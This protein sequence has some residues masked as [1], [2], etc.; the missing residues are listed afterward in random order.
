[1]IKIESLPEGLHVQ[2]LEEETKNIKEKA[3]VIKEQLLKR[4][5][6]SN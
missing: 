3:R 4:N 6:E 5:N 1:M 2:F